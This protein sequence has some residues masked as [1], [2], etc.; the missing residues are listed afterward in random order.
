MIFVKCLLFVQTLFVNGILHFEKYFDKKNVAKIVWNFYFLSDFWP[1]FC[2]SLFFPYFW[3]ARKQITSFLNN[4]AKKFLKRHF[5]VAKNAKTKI[6]SEITKQ[7]SLPAHHYYY[8]FFLLIVSITFF[9]A[10]F[11]FYIDN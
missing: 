8:L 7:A 4:Y 9:G 2:I 6:L 1:N 3:S 10:I 5:L 11:F